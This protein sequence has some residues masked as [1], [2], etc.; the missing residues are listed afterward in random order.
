MS[1]IKYPGACPVCQTDKV[2][3]DIGGKDSSDHWIYWKC[4]GC[5]TIIITKDRDYQLL[6]YYFDVVHNNRRY[7]ATFQPPSNFFLEYQDQEEEIPLE[8]KSVLTFSF[9]P[10][11]T[12]SNFLQKLKTIL[13]F[14]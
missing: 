14:L 4:E 8:W 11:I 2:E 7:S 12:P 5:Q 9:L 6:Y 10:D 1:E 13:T 3:F